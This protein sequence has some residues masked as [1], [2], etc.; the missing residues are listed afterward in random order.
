MTAHY[1][2]IIEQE[3]GDSEFIYLINTHGHYD[4]TTGNQAFFDVPIIAHDNCK[5]EIVDFWNDTARV[6]RSIYEAEE[7]LKNRQSSLEL[8]SDMWKFY[9]SLMQQISSLN[10][11]LKDN[12]N[13]TYPTITFND[14][15]NL[16]LGDVTFQLIYFGEAHTT[17]DIIIYIPEEKT[18]CIGDLFGKGGAP[19]FDVSKNNKRWFEV[20][21]WAMDQ[22]IEKIIYGHGLVI[23][24]DDIDSFNRKLMK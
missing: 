21:D 15:L 20:M 13:V 6:N 14:R 7:R 11:T 24:K 19:D 17:S 22:E 1:K 4:H 18:L 9:E 12:F 23:T 5:S 2:K 8:N 3:F 16:D 10:E